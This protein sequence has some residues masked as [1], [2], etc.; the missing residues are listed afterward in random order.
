ML[1]SCLLFELPLFFNYFSLSQ[2]VSAKNTSKTISSSHT[3]ILYKCWLNRSNNIFP[4]DHIYLLSYLYKY[5]YSSAVYYSSTYYKYRSTEQTLCHFGV[6]SV[7]AEVI[8]CRT[9]AK[10]LF[11]IKYQSCSLKTKSLS[12]K[13]H[14]SP[15][16]L[17]LFLYWTSTYCTSTYCTVLVLVHGRP[18]NA[19]TAD[20]GLPLSYCGT[21]TVQNL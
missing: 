11:A 7:D 14:R 1:V 17:V 2:S 4:D 15:C 20:N 12:I 6:E 8:L 21:C 9:M 5:W 19:D 18:T 16:I 10:L 3:I 13:K